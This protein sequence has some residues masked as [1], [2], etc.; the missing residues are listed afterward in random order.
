MV[1]AN[2]N[3][4]LVGSV[5]SV[6]AGFSAAEVGSYHDLQSLQQISIAGDD[7]LEAMKGIGRQF[8]SLLA[9]QMLKA[10]RSATKV[11]S[12]DS[13]F[14]SEQVDFYQQMMDDQLSLELTRGEGLGLA[15]QFAKHIG[16]QHQSGESKTD[17][18]SDLHGGNHIAGAGLMSLSNLV[19]INKVA[20]AAKQDAQESV[21][22]SQVGDSSQL[23]GN[24]QAAL[25]NNP[26]Q[27]FETPEDF[28]HAMYGHANAAAKK[29][30]VA[31][32]ALIAQ[33]A[34]ETGWG[35][36]VIHHA[37][38]KSSFNLFGI[39]ADARWQGKITEVETLEYFSEVP[40]KVSAKFRSYNSYAESF[41]DYTNFIQTNARYQNATENPQH[42]PR[43]L[44]Q[45]G[46]ATDP[47]YAEKIESIMYRLSSGSNAQAPALGQLGLNG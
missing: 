28:I 5:G 24:T 25:S 6:N 32:E 13:M 26:T 3:N 21:A 11:W 31:P 41:A 10:M 38:G 23:S 47:Q 4:V 35:N 37:D 12:E 39:K 7:N 33:A 45:A 1:A 40:I 27:Y 30:G 17:D 46:Y 34:L 36:K 44:Q 19:R 14:S 20:L 15:K 2:L 42:Y 8:E 16:E 22:F 43:A 9:H 29:L 18:D